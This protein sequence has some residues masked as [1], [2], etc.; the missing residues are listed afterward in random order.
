MILYF[1]GTGNCLAISRQLAERTGDKVMSLYDAVHTDLS[2]HNVVGLVYPTY[3]FNPPAPVLELVRHLTISPTAY[4]YIVVPC[5]AHTGNAVWAIEK[6]LGQ[7]GVQVA[8]CHK[9]RV[10]DCSAVGFG[11]NPNDQKWKFQ[12]YADRV[13]KIAK[14]INAR[15]RAHHFGAWG[16]AGWLCA[17]PWMQKKTKP[18]LQPM[19]NPKRCV[20]CGTCSEVCPQSNILL[21][22]M[23]EDNGVSVKKAV[24]GS[25]CAECLSCVHFCPHQAIE[26]AGRQTPRESQYH[27]PNIKLKDML[28]RR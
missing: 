26:I 24:I 12:K 3:Y 4:V 11:R 13:E 9:V 18:L 14:D 5:G 23:I 21:D 2:Q 22:T 10:P 19:V 27:H 20:G 1:S 25:A 7:K 17:L 28:R 15:V 6:I 8:Y 16:F